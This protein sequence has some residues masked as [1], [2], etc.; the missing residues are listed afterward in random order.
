MLDFNFYAPTQFVFGRNTEHQCG[1]LVRRFGGSR[2][3]VLYGGGSV[4]RSGLLERVLAA[5]D[6]AGVAHIEAGGI[7]PNPRDDLA[8]AL[9]QKAV[10]E[11]ID[12]VIGCGAGSVLDTAKAVAVGAQTPDIPLWAYYSGERTVQSALPVGSIMTFPAT[13]SEGSPS[14]VLNFEK[15]GLKRGLSSDCIRPV[16]AIMNPE[17]TY[18]LPPYQTACGIV[19]MMSHILERYFSETA[20]VELTDR[21]CEAALRSIMEAA[22]QWTLTP[23][24]YDTR[25]TLMW[26]AAI[27]H[28]NSLGVGRQQDWSCHALEHELSYKYDVAHGAG[29][30]VVTLGWMK[31]INARKPQKL[32][33]LAARVLDVDPRYDDPA[34]MGAAGIQKLSAFFECIGMP[35]TFEALGCDPRDI[36][37]LSRTVKRRPDGLLGFYC[38]MNDQDIIDVYR[39]CCAASL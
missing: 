33:Q 34:R 37:A 16:F 15:Q 2:A 7:R 26:A 32:A 24:D 6:R 12:F 3:L 4:V 19:D 23:E 27:A 11:R 1:D 10:Q 38:P 35:L 29:L 30:A 5:L 22:R 18:T 21:L 36:P 9:I 25:A 31:W 14:S 20:G 13:G 17:W 28:N 8:E 39:L